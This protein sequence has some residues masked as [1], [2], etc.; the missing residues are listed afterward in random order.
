MRFF[1]QEIICEIICRFTAGGCAF[2][3][4]AKAGET[5]ATA[6]VVARIT[7]RRFT[8][9]SSSAAVVPVPRITLVLRKEY[10]RNGAAC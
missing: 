1:M 9:F 2:Q 3:S 7:V 5:A 6:L 4:E 8:S 10:G